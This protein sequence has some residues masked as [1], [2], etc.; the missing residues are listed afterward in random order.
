MINILD[1]KKRW[2]NYTKN[3]IIEARVPRNNHLIND[4]DYFCTQTSVS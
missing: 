4:F 3:E 2:Q 1:L